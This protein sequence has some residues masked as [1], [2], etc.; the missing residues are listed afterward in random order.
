MTLKNNIFSVE[1]TLLLFVVT[2]LAGLSFV[3][4]S[5]AETLYVKKSGTKLQAEDSAKSEVI[6][7]LDQGT[8]VSVVKKD[9]RFYQVSAP[10]GKT[11]WVFKFKLTSKVPAKSGGGGGAGLLGALGGRQ[12]IAARES[13]SGSSIRGLSPMS[14]KHAKNKGITEEEIKSVKQMEVFRVNPQEMEKFL[15]EGRLGEYGQ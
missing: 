13:S 14:E 1:K 9:K 11:G 2:L 5:F 10:G 7:K 4:D 15:K 12:K 6:G 3:S 8:P